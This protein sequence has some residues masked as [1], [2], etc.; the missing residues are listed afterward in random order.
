MPRNDPTDTGGMFIGRRPGT[1]PM[2]YRERP[3]L[4]SPTRQ[5]FDRLL[6]WFLLAVEL[7]LCLSL[8]GPQPAGWLWVGSQV[9]YQTGYVTLGISTI[10]LG[11]LVSL[12]LTLV[13]AKRVDH[14]WKLVRRA[15]GHRQERGAIEVIFAVSVALAV[16]AFGIWFLLIEGP[17]SNLFPGREA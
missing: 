12:V 1:A 11:C 14:A 9:E 15:A 4:G 6:A 13:L 2:R 3:V 16:I 5:R 17:G 7:V 10:M 8:F